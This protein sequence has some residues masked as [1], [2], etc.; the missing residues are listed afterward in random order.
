MR[1]LFDNLLLMKAGNIVYLGPADR[2][3]DP[4]ASIAP[5]PAPPLPAALA[6]D[7]SAAGAGTKAPPVWPPGNLHD[8]FKAIGRPLDDTADIADV[9]GASSRLRA[10]T[11]TAC[12]S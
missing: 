7:T 8:Y 5:L 3:M 10:L 9:V 12:A 4:R 2:K 6:V 11:Q 1:S